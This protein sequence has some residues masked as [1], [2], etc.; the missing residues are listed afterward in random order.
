MRQVKREHPATV[1]SLAINEMLWSGETEIY[2]MGDV[3]QKATW[4]RTAAFWPGLRDLAEQYVK[5]GS[6]EENIGAT[7]CTDKK[8]LGVT[9]KSH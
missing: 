8:Q 7:E 5:R 6:L 4:H 2:Q 1:F 9:S 3:S